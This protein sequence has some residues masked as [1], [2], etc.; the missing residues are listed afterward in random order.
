MAFCHQSAYS[1]LSKACWLLSA[2][3]LWRSTSRVTRRPSVS[4]SISL[5]ASLSW[6]SY[7]YY[8]W[9]WLMESCHPHDTC[10]ASSVGSPSTIAVF[11]CAWWKDLFVLKESSACDWLLQQVKLGQ[12]WWSWT[13]V[14]AR[15]FPRVTTLIGQS[16][17]TW[18]AY[19]LLLGWIIDRE[20]GGKKW[21][22]FLLRSLISVCGAFFAV[23]SAVEFCNFAGLFLKGREWWLGRHAQRSGDA[24][25]AWIVTIAFMFSLLLRV[26]WPFANHL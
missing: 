14:L 9:N 1:F 5:S 12:S 19:S 15:D 20:V 11:S 8:R 6:W 10:D 21:L 16:G 26:R 7:G 3:D 25:S 22:V 13:S 2:L 24:L 4:A 23:R 18:R 17:F